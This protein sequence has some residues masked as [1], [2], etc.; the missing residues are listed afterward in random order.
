[1]TT[2]LYYLKEDLMIW[3][4]VLFEIV[5]VGDNMNKQI[6]SLNRTELQ[7]KGL[8]IISAF[9]SKELGHI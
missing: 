1:M 6:S 7:D 2:I 9:I 3:L 5:Q 4:E 8:T